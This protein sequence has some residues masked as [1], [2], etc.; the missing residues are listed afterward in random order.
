MSDLTIYVA[1]TNILSYCKADLCLCFR[2]S[3]KQIV[4]SCTPASA[5]CF[6]KTVCPKR[7]ESSIEVS[8]RRGWGY[9]AYDQRIKV[10][11]KRLKNSWVVEVG[12]GVRVD[13]KKE[14]KLVFKLAKKLRGSGP[15]V[16]WG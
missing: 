5:F 13:M 9:G 12:V 4:S 7:C 10:I 2:I 14:M 11:A 3:I 8:V 6:P 16:G 1:K 15:G